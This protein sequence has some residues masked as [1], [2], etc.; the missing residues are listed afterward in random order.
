MYSHH[1]LSKIICTPKLHS[2]SISTA[3]SLCTRSGSPHNDLHSLVIVIHEN[4]ISA[5]SYHNRTVL[6]AGSV[7]DDVACLLVTG[8]A[9]EKF[10]M[11]V[12]PSSC[13]LQASRHSISTTVATQCSHESLLLSRS[14]C[15]FHLLKVMT[16]TFL[17]LD[18]LVGALSTCESGC[19]PNVRNVRYVYGI[20][21][22]NA[23]TVL[24]WAAISVLGIIWPLADC[25]HAHCFLG[26]STTDLATAFWQT[27]NFRSKREKDS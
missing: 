4:C 20:A 9:L 7:V 26:S 27:E 21:Y 5:Y 24:H 8:Q 6:L 19:G 15:V 18:L 13:F 3:D 22:H 17:F 23:S 12:I 25:Y 1:G 2:S 10:F 16:V 14:N 11:P